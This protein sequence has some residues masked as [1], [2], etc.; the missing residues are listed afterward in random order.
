[1]KFDNTV[2]AGNLL[3]AGAMALTVLVWGVRLESRVDHEKE[4]R[5]RLET[6]VKGALTEMK[7]AQS[8]ALE[9][10]GQRI[11]ED[12]K[13]LHDSDRMLHEALQKIDDKVTQLMRDRMRPEPAGRP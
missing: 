12:T 5:Q 4:L 13:R 10:L 8:S 3:T 9:R 2:T 11:S 6:D 7:G 1:M